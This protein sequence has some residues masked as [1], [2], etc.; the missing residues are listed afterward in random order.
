MSYLKITRLSGQLVWI[1]NITIWPP[2][3]TWRWSQ[4]EKKLTNPSCWLLCWENLISFS[5]SRGRAIKNLS[6]LVSPGGELHW[7]NQGLQVVFPSK[8]DVNE[9]IQLFQDAGGRSK[10]RCFHAANCYTGW[11]PVVWNIFY[12]SIYWECHHPNWLCF[13]SAIL[14]VLHRV[15]WP[16]LLLLL[17]AA[18]NSLCFRFSACG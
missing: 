18:L 2:T 1:R 8:Q 7:P 4:K 10:L 14:T 9:V 13:N 17:A 11:W 16:M 6:P 12:F 15:I 3:D 5:I